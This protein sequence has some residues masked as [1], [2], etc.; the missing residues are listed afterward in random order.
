MFKSPARHVQKPS[1]SFRNMRGVDSE[2]PSFM[3]SPQEVLHADVL[4]WIAWPILKRAQAEALNEALVHGNDG[5]LLVQQRFPSTT[6][7]NTSLSCLL[8]PYGAP[9]P[10]GCEEP[11]RAGGRGQHAGWQQ[12]CQE[13]AEAR[14]KLAGA[15]A[16]GKQSASPKLLLMLLHGP[17]MQQRLPRAGARK[18]LG[19]AG[20]SC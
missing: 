19:E 17:C 8:P 13:A 2:P 15:R 12:P 1:L 5:P 9:A 20:E 10:S 11:G 18:R 6:M 3:H 4:E 7:P 14:H 16:Q